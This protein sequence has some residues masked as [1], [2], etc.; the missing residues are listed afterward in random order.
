MVTL[1]GAVPSAGEVDL[2][3]ALVRGVPGVTRVESAL[4]V[5]GP[6]PRP[7][8]AR[9]PAGSRD[10]PAAPRPRLSALAPPP[11]DGPLRL[12]GAGVSARVTRPSETALGR[13]LAVGPLLRLRPRNGL[14]PT[15]AFNWTNAEIETGA[16][17]RP[18]LAAI[19]L[20]PVM[21]GVELEIGRAACRESV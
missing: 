20:R 1:R 11:E 8:A 13:T 14:G 19:R 9:P 3:L 15:V 21:G 16:M 12:V 6:D 18:G 2:A 4:A 17:G 7:V 10:L 5:G